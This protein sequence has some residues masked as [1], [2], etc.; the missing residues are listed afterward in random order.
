MQGQ[1][2]QKTYS[3]EESINLTQKGFYCAKWPVAA[4]VQLKIES[5]QLIQI[6]HDAVVTQQWQTHALAL[7][8]PL[9]WCNYYCFYKKLNNGLC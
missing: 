9:K 3:T 5:Q 7:Y 4:A 6:N 2:V 8:D 1:Y